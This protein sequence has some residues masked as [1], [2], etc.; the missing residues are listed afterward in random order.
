MEAQR[1]VELAIQLWGTAVVVEILWGAC[2]KG[3][4]EFNLMEQIGIRRK[5]VRN[6]NG[7]SGKRTT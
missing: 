6:W 2:W 4:T 3:N 7:V 5:V 1:R